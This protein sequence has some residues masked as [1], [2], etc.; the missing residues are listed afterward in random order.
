MLKLKI[1]KDYKV[2]IAFI[3]ITFDTTGTSPFQWAFLGVIT[4][5]L[6]FILWPYIVITSINLVFN[7]HIDWFTFNSFIGVW[8]LLLS[9]GDFTSKE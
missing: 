2:K 4:G 5:L 3:T 6:N 8:L 9:L 1:P 7:T